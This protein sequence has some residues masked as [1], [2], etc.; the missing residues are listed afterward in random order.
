MPGE[1]QSLRLPSCTLGQPCARTGYL[2]SMKTLHHVHPC[3][4]HQ[5][6]PQVLVSELLTAAPVLSARSYCASSAVVHLCFLQS[7]SMEV[8]WEHFASSEDM[9]VEYNSP[10]SHPYPY[11]RPGP[12]CSFFLCS[13]NDPSLRLTLPPVISAFSSFW[14]DSGL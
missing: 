11:I 14:C 10:Y 2:S 6:G 7:H 13:I 1:N 9:G 8:T 4:P 12:G 5:K 3:E